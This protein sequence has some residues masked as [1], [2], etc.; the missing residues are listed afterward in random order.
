MTRAA[1]FRILTAGPL[2]LLAACSAGSLSP[3]GADSG[4]VD[5]ATQTACRNR[6]NEVFDQRNRAE[7]FAANSSMNTP[8]S[9]NYQSGVSSRG[10]ADQF[11]YGQMERDCERT[12]GTGADRTDENL[13]P[14]PKAR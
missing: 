6:T 3:D 1:F 7:I 12:T 14:A 2:V 13:M 11:A 9:S 8:F 5:L 4:R 10:L